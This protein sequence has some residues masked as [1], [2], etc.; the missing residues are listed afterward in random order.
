MLSEP[1]FEEELDDED[2]L[3]VVEEA[4]RTP[5]GVT[6]YVVKEEEAGDR[7]DRYLVSRLAHFSRNQVQNLIDQGRVR[8]NDVPKKPSHRLEAGEKV[9]IEVPEP[10]PVGV[11]PENILLDIVYS[12]SDIA[13][14][15]KPAG[16]I[17]HPGAG[18]DAGTLA[19]ALLH[20]FGGAKKL[21]ALGGPLRPG[22]VHRLDKDTSGLIVV[23]LTDAAHEK[24]VDDFRERRVQKTYIALLHGKLTGESGA[25]ELP[26]A[27][28]SK[29]RSRMTARRREGR[30]A[31]TDWRLRLRF[32]NFAFVEADLHT[33]R[34]HQIR[35]HFSALGAPVVGDTVYGAPRQ[36]RIGRELLPPLGRNFLHSARLAFDHPI[37]GKRLEFR[38]PLPDELREYLKRLGHATNANPAAIDAALAE[39]L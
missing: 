16:M 19:A 20:H 5:A 13:V 27:R 6:D 39:F 2:E 29:R 10:A 37:T 30:E 1:E 8:V 24:L 34:T 32:D 28:D 23:A 7:L 36:E 4:A 33:G 35:V 22:I 9:V 31:R 21:S 18:E 38:A 3:A 12:D 14:I 15:N 25:I 11:E 26:I 17:V